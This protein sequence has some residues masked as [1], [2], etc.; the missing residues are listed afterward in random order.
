[1]IDAGEI[2]VP[3][4]RHWLSELIDDDL[5]EG[6]FKLRSTL[7]WA[8]ALRFVIEETHGCDATVQ[9]DS[10]RRHF[11]TL[12][13]KSDPREKMGEVYCLLNHALTSATSL[14][15]LD[16]SHAARPWMYPTTVV[17]WYYAHYQ[18]F[19]AMALA[20]G[21]QLHDTHA[22]LQHSINQGLRGEL[23]HPYDMRALHQGDGTYRVWLPAARDASPAPL[24]EEFDETSESARGMLLRYL[25]STAKW[26]KE[27]VQRGM[28]KEKD[29]SYQNFKSK[30]ARDARN[31][32]LKKDINFLHCAF[33]YRGNANYRDPLSLTYGVQQHRH[34]AAFAHNLAVSA[35]FAFIC[36]LAFAERVYGK[37][38]T[39]EFLEDLERN[40]RGLAVGTETELFWRAFR[41]RAQPAQ[42]RESASHR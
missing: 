2:E 4:T 10:C 26:E 8:A 23:P 39:T 14:V 3:K 15:S 35:R 12:K 11:S 29:F 9:F 34:Y 33:R 28:L 41:T 5:R 18:A 27:D 17:A 40:F 32:R 13:L 37:E 21:L 31:R 22:S 1:M 25:D 42:Q 6:V 7:S 20:R 30:A 38:S 19:R 16:C 36:G 24:I